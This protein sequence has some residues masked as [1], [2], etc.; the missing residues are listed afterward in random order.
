MI[1][2]AAGCGGG[3]A[4]E[5]QGANEPSG[6]FEVDV[7]KATF[8]PKQKLAKRSQLAINV[9]NTGD[10]TVP[11]LAVTVEGFDE[12]QTDPDAETADARTTVFAI[13]GEPVNLKQYGGFDDSLPDTPGDS[14]TAFVDTWTVGPVKPGE[15]KK[16]RWTVTAARRGAY[17]VKY[18]VA[19]GLDGK[20][21]AVGPDGGP[22]Q[23]VFAGTI[24]AAA[25]DERVS[26]RD[27]RT[28]IPGTR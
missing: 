18:E 14:D 2:L 20:A 11:N 16:L 5:R 12:L 22:P 9:E 6:K 19:A 10:R 27:G 7:T 4:D 15:T 3:G 23:G 24:S 26:D 8:P 21:K 17:R 25:P 1:A 13:N 28:I